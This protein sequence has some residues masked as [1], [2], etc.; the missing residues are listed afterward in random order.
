MVVVSRR[1]ARNSLALHCLGTATP[2]SLTLVNFDF[3][4]ET[5]C[6]IKACTASC[7]IIYI[8]VHNSLVIYL[9]LS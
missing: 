6:R 7:I 2:D 8:L 9:L 4:R 5:L 1:D 3:F